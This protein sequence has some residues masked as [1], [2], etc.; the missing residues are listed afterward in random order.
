MKTCIH[1]EADEEHYCF[2]L[3]RYFVKQLESFGCP[4]SYLDRTADKMVKRTLEIVLD[5]ED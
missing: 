5:G 2:R 4:D 3:H 1:G